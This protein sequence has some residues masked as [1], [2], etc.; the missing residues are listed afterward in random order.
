MYPRRMT[1]HAFQW[2][3]FGTI[4]QHFRLKLQRCVCTVQFLHKYKLQPRNYNLAV[5]VEAIILLQI[6]WLFDL[7]HGFM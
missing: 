2:R 4:S 3:K 6:L 7:F 5:A 1:V